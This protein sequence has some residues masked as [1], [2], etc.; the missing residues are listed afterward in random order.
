MFGLVS[1]GKS[2]LLN[3]LIGEKI[4]E[5]GPL[6]GVTQQP[7]IVTWSPGGGLVSGDRSIVPESSSKIQIELI[8]T[9]G[10]D[11]IDGQAR[12]EMAQTVARQA[13][14]ILF[15][16]SGD[17]TRTEYKALCNLRQAQKPL[18]LRIQQSRSLSR[19]IATR[20]LSQ[21]PELGK[22]NGQ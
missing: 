3:A 6:N 17:M 22:Q 21:S 15:V 7:R 19:S 13:D 1:R 8:D 5:T 12:A 20:Y 10:L 11:E 2:A 9:P 4:F 14:L 18:I 16:I